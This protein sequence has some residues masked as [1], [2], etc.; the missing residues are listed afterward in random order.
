MADDAPT[1][2]H[3]SKVLDGLAE[4]PALPASMVCRLVGYR[5]GSGYVATRADLTL[6]LIEEILTSGH[7]WLLHSLALNPR[8][9]NTVRMR[10]AAHN[11]P[12]I[13]AALAARARDAPRDLYERL[14]DDPDTRVRSYLAER[15]DVPADL[16][17]QLAGDPDPQVRTTLARWWTQAPET[18]RRILLTDPVGEVRAAACTT[19]YARSP[20]PVPPPD[21]VT[22]LLA[23]PVTR[24]GAVRHAIL[25]PELAARLAGD[26]DHQVRRQLAEHPQL[27]PPVRDQLTDDPSANVRVGIFGRRD[28]P[29][30]ARHRIFED[31]QQGERPLTD[32][33]DDELDDD[34]LLQQVEDHMALAELRCLRLDWVTADPLPHLSSPYICFRR[35]AARSRTLPAD[36]VIRLLNDDDSGVRTTMATHAPHLVDPATAERIDRE[37]QPD[38]KTNWR[39]A[40]DFT[41]PPQTLRRLATDPDPRMRC[42]APRDEDLPVELAERLAT[43]PEIVVRHAV[44]G[45]PNLPVHV[46][47]TLLADPNEWVAHATAAAPTL[48]VPEMDRLL[49]L[50]GI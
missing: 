50:A 22:G 2:V 39:P 32:L 17:A 34:A 12:A 15:D 5:R 40:D 14:I 6:D 37:F 27:P 18:V 26:P 11:D 49:T 1:P 45:H 43:D 4:N 41:F 23:D 38:K 3:L 28:T 36:A 29:E 7:H 8:L 9:P 33:L 19:Y 35:S 46:R 44:A 10:L 42:L 30:P 31:I 13:R 21:L 47:R 25:T 20:H 48:P 16:L 24:A